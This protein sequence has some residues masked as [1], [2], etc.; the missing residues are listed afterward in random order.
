MQL[1]YYPAQ[2]CRCRVRFNIARITLYQITLRTSHTTPRQIE[3]GT[4]SLPASGRYIGR[5]F[6]APRRNWSPHFTFTFHISRLRAADALTLTL[7]LTPTLTVTFQNL[8]KSYLVRNLPVPKF[9]ENPPIT[10]WVIVLTNRQT[11]KQTGGGQ[12]RTPPKV[13]EAVITSVSNGLFSC[14]RR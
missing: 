7:S 9:N 14:W 6:P 12:N 10:F 1:P 13:T 5:N 4:V 2:S 11:N 3:I 8:I